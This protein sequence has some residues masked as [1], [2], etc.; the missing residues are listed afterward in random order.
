MIESDCLREL[1]RIVGPA[2]VSAGRADGEIYSYDGSLA[3]GAPDAIVFP[4]DTR[5]T[6]AVIRAASKAGVPCTPRGFGTNLSGGS[7][8]AQGGV[9]VCFSRMNRI[10]AIQPERRCAVVQPGVTNLE[11]QEALAP[12]GFFY[13]PD[14]ASQKVAT[15]GGN[16]GEN[17]GGPHCLKYGITTNHVLGL[18]AVLPDGEIVRFGG[19]ALD[20]PGFDLRGLFVG[21]EGTL[22]AVTEI[23]VRI[24]PRPES[25][26]T[27]LAIY[28]SVADAARSV[29]G[30]IAKGIVPATLEMMDALVMRAVEESMKCGY[31]P[32]AAA[33]LIIEVEGPAAGLETEVESILE[34]CK[35]NGCRSIREAKDSAERDLLWA[36]RRGAFGAVARIAPNYLV[37]DCT[38]PRTR[39]PDALAQVAAITEKHGL[40]CG[41]VF[42][43]GDGNLH[44]LLLFDARDKDQLRRVYLAGQEIMEACVALGGT[45]TGEHGIGTEKIEAM[46]L[47]FSDDDLAFQRAIKQAFDPADLF[48]PGKIVKIGKIGDR[49]LI[50]AAGCGG[51]NQSPD[52]EISSLS[53][54]LGVAL[55]EYDPPN[56][57]VTAAAGMR[58][59]TLQEIL[60]AN[61]QWLPLRP[62]LAEGCTLG[63]VVA[64]GACGPERLR[65]GAPRDLLLGLRF[66]SGEGRQIRAGGKVVKNVA[67]YDM[68]RLIAGSMGALGFITELTFRVGTLPEVCRAVRA[69]GSLEKVAAAADRV[70]RSSIEPT[71]VTAVPTAPGAIADGNGAWGLTIGFEGLAVRVCAQTEHCAR[72]L[73]EAGL[74]VLENV[75]YPARE[76]LHAKHHEVL[77]HQPF[78]LRADLPC[79]LVAKFVTDAADVFDG[80]NVLVDLGCGRVAAGLPALASDGWLRVCRLAEQ[81]QGHCVL[82]KASDDFKEHHD[83]F[84]P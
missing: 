79:D 48:N 42:H 67:G 6:A 17:S 16:V 43:A 32:D 33:V 65:Y 4:A 22:G 40:L 75:D 36:G 77:F 69:R 1:R 8:S 23:T 58:L 5:Q 38:V 54:I 84:G 60:S 80:A 31:P 68:T 7:V 76:G 56:Q 28:D 44:P 35:A 18:E 72:L 70:L 3:R 10:L 20:P 71:F 41:N 19:P 83:V 61:N 82:E 73:K 52:T 78:L 34:I 53:P 13:A 46:R 74:S 39:L 24:L 37:N 25:V 81:A 9:V 63:G 26:R 50:S 64:L 15:L 47:V 30:I 45:I 2:H 29:S 49:L 66:I 51:R 21:S 59:T 27:L 12:L 62:P 14:P 55:I 11:L 57:V